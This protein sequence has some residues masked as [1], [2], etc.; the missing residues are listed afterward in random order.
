M[1]GGQSKVIYKE[2]SYKIVGI[3][4]S[5]YNELGYGY[6]ENTYCRAIKKEFGIN[7]LVYKEQ[8]YYRLTYKGEMIGR[9]FLDFLVDN[10]IV[11]EIKKGDYFSKKNIEQVKAYLKVTN[12][13]LA[14]LVNFTS[15]GVKFLRILNI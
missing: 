4:F 14:V 5:V 3:M 9:Y 1:Q 12:L 11:V 8:V 6:P 13:K 2:L 15:S 10:K 7:N